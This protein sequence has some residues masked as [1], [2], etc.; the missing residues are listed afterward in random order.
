MKDEDFQNMKVN[1]ILNFIESNTKQYRHSGSKLFRIAY[2]KCEKQNDKNKMKNIKNEILAF[3]LSTHR[4]PEKRFSPL[5]E[6][7]LE[8]GERYVY[9]DLNKQFPDETIDYYKKRAAKTKNPILEARYCDIVWDLRKEIEY[10]EKAIEAY[11]KCCEVYFDNEWDSELADSLNRALQIAISIN[12]N[13][14]IKSVLDT[15]YNFISKLKSQQRYNFIKDII[16]FILMNHKR[17][18]DYLDLNFFVQT[19][20]AALEFYKCPER[21]NFHLQRILLK[22]LIKIKKIENQNEEVRKLELNIAE[23]YEKEAKWKQINYQ[24]GNS[25]A[26]SVYQKALQKY[27]EIGNC[28]EKIKEIKTKIQTALE[29]AKET[30]FQLIQVISEIPRK[31]IDN[32]LN[33]FKGL[34]INEALEIIAVD[35]TLVPSYDDCRKEAVEIYNKYVFRSMIPRQF[36]FDDIVIKN[37]E[38]K[39]EKIAFDAVKIFLDQ[40]YVISILFKEIIKTILAEHPNFFDEIINYLSKSEIV[41]TERITIIRKGLEHYKKKD[42]I[43]T[44]YLLVF[45]IE[46][47]LRDLLKQMRI[48]TFTYRNKEMRYKTLYEIIRLLEVENGFDIDLLKFI[49]FFL[50]DLRGDNLRNEIAHGILRKEQFTER[51]AN[52]LILLLIKLAPYKLIVKETS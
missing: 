32:Y 35:K 39:E 40:C 15:A 4:F 17:I 5:V 42:Y 24:K 52:L 27:V 16:D 14:L 7:M 29:A 9:P 34:S 19:L 26:S 13:G 44:I 45:Q 18:K 20:E 47:I 37:I 28:E 48:P 25:I 1:E 6:G 31:D 21:G 2:E 51:N 10:A 41:S 46:G 50:C 30:D 8:N 49:Q 36:I 22:L 33:R 38:T 11:L 3:D 12:N 23:I 43:G